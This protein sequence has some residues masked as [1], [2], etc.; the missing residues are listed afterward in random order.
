MRKWNLLLL[1]VLLTPTALVAQVKIAILDLDRAMV[2]SARGQAAQQELVAYQAELAAG[3]EAT[4]DQLA[5][6]Q[7]RAQTQQRVLSEEALN[8]LSL[9]M[10]R[11]NRQLDRQ[12]EDANLEMESKQAE[13]YNPVLTDLVAVVEEYVDREGITLVLPPDAVIYAAEETNITD[14]IIA[15]FNERQPAAATSSTPAPEPPAPAAP[16]E[17]AT[18]Q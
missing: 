12:V 2:E 18:G 5:G 8:A 15:M 10:E 7:Q 1:A 6:M 13:V 11:L 16:A 17:G 9:D 3:I 4:Q 14:A